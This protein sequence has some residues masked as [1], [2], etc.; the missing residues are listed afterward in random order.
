LV[1]QIDE[2]LSFWQWKASL[3]VVDGRGHPVSLPHNVRLYYQNGFGHVGAA[4]LLAPPQPAGGCE[5]A[6]H[7]QSAT[8]AFVPRALA[9][10]ID[11]WADKGIEPPKSNFPRIENGTLVSLGAYRKLFPEVPG[12]APPQVMNELDVLDFGPR[13]SSIG[14]VQTK[15]PPVHGPSY[16]LFVPRPSGDGT[17][18]GG[19]NSLWTRVPLGTNVGW[20][21]RAGDRKPDLCFLNGSFV[22][23]AKTK[24]ERLTKRDPRPSLE[25]RYKDHIGFVSAVQTATESLVKERF[26]LP[27]DAAIF[28]K[29][30]RE[31]DVLK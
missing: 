27:E 26:L 24:A 15:L 13:F 7:N 10:A 8:I 14:G 21:V 20:N 5:Q 23:F 4:G 18:V 29:G 12:F 3:N 30:A 1:F 25:E 9:I 16:Q 22:P 17:G 2:E 31:S 19:I 28:V 11:E 6:T